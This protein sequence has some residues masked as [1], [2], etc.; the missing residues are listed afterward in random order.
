VFGERRTA[1][2]EAENAKMAASAGGFGTRR[3]RKST[4]IDRRE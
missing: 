4:V 2:R 1:Y 3:T